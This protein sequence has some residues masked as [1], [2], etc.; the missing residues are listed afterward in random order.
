MNDL[1]VSQVDLLKLVVARGTAWTS[2]IVA[3]TDRDPKQINKSML[4]LRRRGMISIS[5][6]PENNRHVIYQPTDAGKAMVK[7]IRGK[8]A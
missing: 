6:D 1:S 3:V 2:D 8:F 4:L 5:R 7:Y